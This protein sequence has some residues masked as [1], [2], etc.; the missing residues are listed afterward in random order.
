LSAGFLVAFQL[1]GVNGF[2]GA[3]QGHAA[4]GNDAFFHRSAGG[5]Q[6]VVHTGLLFLHFRFRS[7]THMDDG[8]AGVV[9]P[10]KVTRSALQNAASIAGLLL[11][12]ECV[13]ADKPEKKGCGCGSGAPDMGGMGGMGGMGMM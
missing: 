7:G 13:I 4:A 3:D 5:V 1:E 6:G 10:T 8:H 9:D 12:T 2:L 11:T